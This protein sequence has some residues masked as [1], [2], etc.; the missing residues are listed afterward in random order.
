M[1]IDLRKH[2]IRYN[3]NHDGM[4]VDCK[5]YYEALNH[6]QRFKFRQFIEELCS[7]VPEQEAEKVEMG[8]SLERSFEVELRLVIEDRE[9][10]VD[11]HVM[12][13]AIQAWDKDETFTEQVDPY[14]LYGN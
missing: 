11:P 3:A 14:K 12:N 2:F 4:M 10:V 5:L 7:K 6:D 1:A 8:C 9:F 13:K